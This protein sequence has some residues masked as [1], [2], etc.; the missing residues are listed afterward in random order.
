VAVVRACEVGCVILCE[1]FP[2][3]QLVSIVILKS[4][5]QVGLPHVKTV[6]RVPGKAARRDIVATTSMQVTLLH[7]LNLHTA[8]AVVRHVQV[9][10]VADIR[11]SKAADYV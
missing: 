4:T 10:L 11:E 3:T 2:A 1:P 6:A 9:A 7:N 5:R 8:G